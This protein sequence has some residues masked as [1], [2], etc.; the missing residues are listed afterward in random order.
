MYASSVTRSNAFSIQLQDPS[1]MF[2]ARFTIPLA[3]IV[4]LLLLTWST[5]RWATRRTTEAVVLFH[6]PPPVNASAD[7]DYFEV[8]RTLL[9]QLTAHPTTRTSRDVVVMVTPRTPEWQRAAIM[10]FGAK[11]EERSVPVHRF[12]VVHERWTEA[13]TKLHAFGITRYHRILF[14]DSDIL[15]LQSPNVIFDAT[16]KNID[17]NRQGAL[18]GAVPDSGTGGVAVPWSSLDDYRHWPVNTGVFV[19]CPSPALHQGL[20]QWASSGP[21]VEEYNEQDQTVLQQYFDAQGPSPVVHL[22]LGYNA[23]LPNDDVYGAHLQGQEDVVVLHGH[24]WQDMPAQQRKI[25]REW[26]RTRGQMEQ[27]TSHAK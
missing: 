8:I 19:G 5:N 26:W 22:P 3:A 15:L 1:N 20:L 21:A 14:L 9:Y 10:Q 4:T 16:R 11:I 18:F 17:C 7:N 13:M 12:R 23:Y 6:S 24:W 27:Y 2:K 25:S